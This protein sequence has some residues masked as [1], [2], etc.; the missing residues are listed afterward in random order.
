MKTMEPPGGRG[1]RDTQAGDITAHKRIQDQ[2]QHSRGTSWEGPYR[3]RYS[4]GGYSKSIL[5]IPDL[6]HQNYA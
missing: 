6:P 5:G 1:E 2:A 4:P 3:T